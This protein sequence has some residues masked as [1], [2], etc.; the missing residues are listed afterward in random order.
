MVAVVGVIRTAVFSVPMPATQI[1]AHKQPKHVVGYVW[2]MME[3]KCHKEV[4][5]IQ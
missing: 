5:E 1:C 4:Y 3:A 2:Y